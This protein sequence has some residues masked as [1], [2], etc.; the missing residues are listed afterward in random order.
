METPVVITTIPKSIIP[1]VIINT[2]DSLKEI[3]I[4]KN[5]S[6]ETNSTLQYYYI[7]NKY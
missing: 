2:F 6:S 1:S 5:I 7:L 4:D 3:L